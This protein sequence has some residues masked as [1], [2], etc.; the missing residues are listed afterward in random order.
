MG[1]RSRQGQV[2]ATYTLTVNNVGT[3]ATAGTV[4]VTDALP[5]GL[6]ATALN[7]TGWA[8]TLATLSCTR[9]DALGAGSSYPSITLT[10]DVETT[11][12]SSV[13]NIATA[14]GGGEINTANDTANDLTTISA[15]A[16]S[17]PP[18][19]PGL[20]TAV[21]TSGTTVDLSWGAATDNVGVTG[22]RV[23]RCE[24]VGCTVF[25]K[26]STANPTGT[27]LTDTGLVPNTSYSYVVR[28][29]DAA[30]NIGPLSNVA[31]VTTLSTIPELVAAY[32]LN[33]GA[34]STVADLSGRGNVGTILNAAWTPA[35]KYGGALSSTGRTLESLPPMRLPCSYRR[36]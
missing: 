24:G 3:A 7:G 27:T 17:E 26:L 16:D 33:E 5:S 20:L 29:V 23:E 11:A 30:A 15:S 12:P 10:V 36:G 35:G 14:A 4:T 21:A 34:G 25:I 32:S 1:G 6:I 8:C 2:G 22:Y 31:T 13:T 9:S 18:S 28:A 19:A